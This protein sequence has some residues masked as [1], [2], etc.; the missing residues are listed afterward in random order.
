MSEMGHSRP[1]RASSKPGQVRDAPKAE[2]FKSIDGSA[3]GRPGLRRLS[4]KEKTLRARWPQW[5]LR[6][7]GDDERFRIQ[8]SRKREHHGSRRSAWGAHSSIEID[9]CGLFDVHDSDR[10]QIL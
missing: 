7:A 1:G 6:A 8:I 4:M 10:G 3:M 5:R 9:E 2:V